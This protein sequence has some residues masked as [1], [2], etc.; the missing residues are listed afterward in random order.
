[1]ETYNQNMFSN[2]PDVVNVAELQEMLRIGR[3]KAYSLVQ[4]GIIK[5]RYIDGIGYR[6]PKINVI[7]Y[8][9]GG[10]K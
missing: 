2:Y 8:M 1:M 5:A 9:I 7:Q 10:D 6:I 3:N 4:K